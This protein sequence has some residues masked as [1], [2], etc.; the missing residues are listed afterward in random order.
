MAQGAARSPL[1]LPNRRKLPGPTAIT[2]SRQEERDALPVIPQL[3]E[4]VERDREQLLAQIERPG[5]ALV[6]EMVNSPA[7]ARAQW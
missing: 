2:A 3:K 6:A 5:E 4:G 7:P 1:S